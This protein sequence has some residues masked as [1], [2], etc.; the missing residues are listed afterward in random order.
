MALHNYL[1]TA[2]LLLLMAMLPLGDLSRA[3]A[4]V[5]NRADLKR[6]IANRKLG[7]S[8]IIDNNTYTDWGHV[9]IPP[10]A[11]CTQAKPCTLTAQTEGSVIFSGQGALTLEIQAA[12]WIISKLQWENQTDFGNFSRPEPSSNGPLITFNGAQDI[13]V[14]DI[15][16]KNI[17]G[18]G[19]V[20]AVIKHKVARDTLRNT[21][22]NSIFDGFRQT[23]KGSTFIYVLGNSKLG[24]NTHFNIIG[25]TFKNRTTSEIRDLQYWIRY[26]NSNASSYLP[27]DNGV[28]ENLVDTPR[29][30][31]LVIQG[32]IFQDDII[33]KHGHDAM[34]LKASGVLIKGNTFNNISRIAFR[35]GQNNKFI[36]NTVINPFTDR[37]NHSLYMADIGHEI[38]NNLFYTNRGDKTAI[39]LSMGTTD[40]DNNNQLDYKA[41]EGSLFHNTFDGWTKSA[42]QTSKT[43]KGNN[44]GRTIINPRN[45]VFQNNVIRQQSGAMINGRDC[46]TLFSK[47]DHNSWS[48]SAKPKCIQESRK[49]KAQAAPGWVNPRGGNYQLK[50]GSP[51]INAGVQIPSFPETRVTIDGKQRDNKPDIGAYEL[52]ASSPPPASDCNSVFGEA[53]DYELCEETSSSCKFNVT[54]HG[55]DC[56]TLC[57]SFGKA[58][59]G[60]F[61]NTEPGCVETGVDTCDTTRR[62]EICVCER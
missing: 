19:V 1:I 9:V 2:T 18:T 5:K 42:I 8:I 17:K 26:G 16:I 62:N 36:G 45:I 37:V 52:G 51:L 53:P 32:N 30:S 41:F 15:T 50:A 54:L 7:K 39:Q 20:I 46:K 10:T 55:S 29:N 6:A 13:I 4:N 49:N 22:Q 47:I 25:N 21:L 44:E 43:R 58:C 57:R 40:A 12:W 28:V 38:T 59:V 35:N 33:G 31:R 23:G 56:A 3:E 11:D 60:A 24:F 61:D 14:D 27:G 34:H 48:G